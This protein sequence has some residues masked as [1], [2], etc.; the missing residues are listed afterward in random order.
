MTGDKKI[1]TSERI[2]SLTDDSVYSQWKKEVNWWKFSTHVEKKNQAHKMVLAMCGKPRHIAT[3]LDPEQLHSETGLVDLIKE[4]DKHYLK[5]NTQSLFCAIDAF[6]KYTRPKGTSIDEYISEFTRLSGIVIECRSNSTG[7][8]KKDVYE[9]GLLAYKLL[10]Q[11]NLSIEEQRLVRATTVKLEF[12]TMAESLKRTYGDSMSSTNLS[13]SLSYTYNPASIVKEEST[14]YQQSGYYDER[15]YDKDEDDRV[16]YSN[17][18]D[19]RY[20]SGRPWQKPWQKNRGSNRGDG[21]FNPYGR[22]QQNN[23]QNFKS[24]NQSNFQRQNSGRKKKEC[25][26]CSDPGHFVSDCPQNT[27]QGGP[28]R[29]SPKKGNCFVC[30]SNQ[31]FMADCPDRPHLLNQ[32]QGNAKVICY[33]SGNASQSSIHY[34]EEE[35]QDK[36]VLDTGAVTT[37]CG[38]RWFKRYMDRC[39]PSHQID[40]EQ[41]QETFRFGDGRVFSSKEVTMLPVS[42][43]KTEGWIQVHL[44]DKPVPLLISHES[45]AVMNLKL[46]IPGR[47]IKS[48]LNSCEDPI[49]I[50]ST[51]HMTMKI[52]NPEFEYIHSQT[53]RRTGNEDPPV[54][55]RIFKPESSVKRNWMP[56][57]NPF[58]EVEVCEET[59]NNSSRSRVEVHSDADPDN[60]RNSSVA[61]EVSQH[62]LEQG[63]ESQLIVNLKEEVLENPQDQGLETQPTHNPMDDPD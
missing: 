53:L 48:T 10:Q 34:D 59:T 58:V 63:N 49:I 44:V 43:C 22:N 13:S 6:E 47:K 60:I 45:M 27:Y 24:G 1:F 19:N 25:F 4:L 62:S 17:S 38:K 33:Q 3:Q 21:R 23:Q 7:G 37:I 42:Y 2:P 28:N 56:E 20:R 16:Y 18:G 32:Q 40:V 61:E 50:T 51:K 36:G 57:T 5:D 29:M 55:R 35:M 41:C 15:N 9:D 52:F 14:F 54:D 12:A 46:D 8:G 30:D 11:S 39:H 31:H 26:I